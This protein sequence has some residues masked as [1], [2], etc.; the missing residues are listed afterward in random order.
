MKLYY[1]DAEKIGDLEKLQYT[2]DGEFQNQAVVKSLAK[3]HGY[4]ITRIVPQK[5]YHRCSYCGDIVAG[6]EKE[7]LCEEC[8]SR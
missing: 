6:E 7:V 8:N 1:A 3:K 2:Y 5:G 4:R